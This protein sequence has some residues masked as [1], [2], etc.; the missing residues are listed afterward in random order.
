MAK[1][2]VE[3]VEASRKKN[4]WQTNWVDIKRS[5][6]L[7]IIILLPI[8]YLVIFAYVPMY[9]ILLAFKRFSISRGVFNSPWVGL[10]YFKQF[11][12]STSSRTIIGN[13]L[14][15]NIISLLFGFPI[16]IILAIALN[17]IRSIF[18]KK[19]VQMVTY[20][21]YFISTVVMVGILF[22]VLD[23]N[24]GL[25]NTIITSLGFQ[26]INFMEKASWFV[27]VYVISGIWQ[28]AGYS[29]IIYISA[30]SG[31]DKQLQEAAIIDGANRLRRIWH[32]DLPAILP[33]VVIMLIFAISSMMNI[34]F[35]KIF[36]MQNSINASASEVI[37]TFVYKVGLV[38]ADY[39]FSTAVGLFNSVVNVLLLLF[40][41]IAA[42]RLTG[43]GVI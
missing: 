21:P 6:Q 3:S 38:N 33:T 11:F 26:S 18:F 17:E 31:V 35:E 1:T 13:T 25:V 32:I 10:Y 41:N 12:N 40:A 43:T 16:P 4:N 29:A 15:I 23:P 20:A 27:P 7:Y 14:Y 36:L 22:Q 34:G 5:W 39:S 37:S 19:T 30:L 2:R 28:G 42:K 24:R 9:G 8:A